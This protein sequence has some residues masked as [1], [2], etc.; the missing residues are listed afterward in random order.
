MSANVTL[1]EPNERTTGRSGWP[2]WLMLVLFL[3]LSLI[4]H[5]HHELW[6]DEV[7]CWLEARSFPVF[8]D[9]LQIEKYCGAPLLWHVLLFPL[10]HS[11]LPIVAMTVLHGTL[12]LTAVCLVLFGSPF[13]RLE[14]P[15]LVFGHYLLYEYNVS[16]RNYV[17]VA[18]LL[19]WLAA[20]YTGR[21]R[22]PLAP[23]ILLA[24]MANTNVH[25]CLISLALFAVLMLTWRR[26]NHGL[27]WW[28]WM[29]GPA[30]YLL[31]LAFFY[32][33]M[34]PPPDLAPD[35]AGLTFVSLTH[36]IYMALLANL[37]AFAP[38]NLVNYLPLTGRE[39]A[40]LGA[41]LYALAI[42]VLWPR[43]RFAVVYGLASL[44][45]LTLFSIKFFG[46]VRHHGMVVMTLVA[47]VW[48]MRRPQP[49]LETTS[50]LP[51]YSRVLFPILLLGQFAAGP[52]VMVRDYKYPY[53]E[54][55]ATGRYLTEHG[56]VGPDTFLAA[57]PTAQ[58]TTIIPY[59]PPAYSSLYLLDY[60]SRGTFLVMNRYWAD[61][62]NLSLEEITRRLLVGCYGGHWKQ[63]LLILSEPKKYGPL[64]GYLEPI[65]S[66]TDPHTMLQDETFGIYRLHPER[67]PGAPPA[68]A[69]TKP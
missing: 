16:S 40:V 22:H 5:T 19:F 2:E 28:R 3:G 13:T 10:A 63:V 23:F 1:A 25:G 48:M 18:L 21:K 31:G 35:H 17:L 33:Q 65:A 20:L 12:A 36:N 29:P 42:A 30:I 37:K 66:F 53:S 57:Y 54:G 59:L 46:G 41:V 68:T 44:A 51:R 8:W 32:Y 11:G 27:P 14:K 38:N 60:Q 34:Q 62:Q 39:L 6:R 58:A 55:A 64:P 43:K 50:T 26:D 45:L 47:C 67:L 49:G 9:V 52:L 24:M 15:L 7:Q 69:T 4:L 56:L 61:N